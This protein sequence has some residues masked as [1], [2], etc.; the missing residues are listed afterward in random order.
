MQVHDELAALFS[1]NLTL[2]PEA[3]AAILSKEQASQPAPPAQSPPPP[4][5][6]TGAGPV[7]PTPVI[8]YSISQHYH[9]SAHL[10]NR[11]VAP[12]QPAQ[13]PAEEQQRATSMPLDM[14]SAVALLRSQGVDPAVLSA[15]Q[16]HLFRTARDANQ[17]QR[18]VELWLIYPP[19]SAAENPAT[20]WSMTTIDQEEQLARLRFER[21][22]AAGSDVVRQQ[23]QQQ[24]QQTQGTQPETVLSLDGTP[25]RA[26]V[27][28][29]QADD[30]H[31]LLNAHAT[32]APEPY[33][34]SGYEELARREYEE[35][36]RR[37]QEQQQQQKQQQYTPATD[38]V[39]KRMQAM[40]DQYGFWASGG[41]CIADEMEIL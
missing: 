25:V 38:P 11:T 34:V 37:G 19:A 35:S 5:P 17:R 9:H 31:W 18:L 27:T 39:Y 29:L 40:E 16:L 3:A 6:R 8:T 7:A 30:G 21:A 15:S 41:A 2:N 14:N 33:M 22:T 26:V 10:A 23:Q 20:A 28:P 1:R 32:A 4:Q 36:M 24:T 12:H 13:R